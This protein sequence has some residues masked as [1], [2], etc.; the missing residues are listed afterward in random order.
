MSQD[1][2]GEVVSRLELG[3]PILGTPALAGGAFY[4]RSDKHLWKFSGAE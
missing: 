3:E 2:K 1:K 4:V